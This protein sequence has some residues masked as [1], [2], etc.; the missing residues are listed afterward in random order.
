MAMVPSLQRRPHD[1]VRSMPVCMPSPPVARLAPGALCVLSDTLSP[2]SFSRSIV[3]YA[4]HLTF[5]NPP[6]IHNIHLTK[7][8][9]VCYLGQMPLLQAS[10]TLLSRR[11]STSSLPPVW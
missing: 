8:A 4:P 11:S 3:A 2:S 10:L 5:P 1:R 6:R 7:M 9:A